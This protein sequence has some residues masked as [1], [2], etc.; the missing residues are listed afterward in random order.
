M[1]EDKKSEG[2]AQQET[3]DGS[4]IASPAL[5]AIDPEELET[6]FAAL[7]ASNLVVGSICKAKGYDLRGLLDS[8]SG[9]PDLYEQ[10]LDKLNIREVTMFVD[11]LA[12]QPSPKGG[13]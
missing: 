7:R 1:N 11:D 10:V 12:S 8:F 3:L 13:V 6:R 5:R 9:R 4:A 2:E